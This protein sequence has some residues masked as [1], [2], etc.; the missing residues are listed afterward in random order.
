MTIIFMNTSYQEEK[1]EIGL[2]LSYTFLSDLVAQGKGK[3]TAQ[4]KGFFEISTI[5]FE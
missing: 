4:D 3:Q 2:Y 1:H 5:Q